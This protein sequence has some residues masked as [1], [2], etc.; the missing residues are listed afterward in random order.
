MTTVDYLG[1]D[2]G[3][4]RGLLLSLSRDLERL[5]SGLQPGPEDL[6]AAPLLRRWGVVQRP[7]FALQGRTYGHPAIDDGRI[8]VASEVFAIDRRKG[9]AR[10][11]S[12]YYSL[13]SSGLYGLDS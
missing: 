13:G 9:W 11:L 10:T 12:R 4:I 6:V 2:P 5:E 7:C 8:A 1:S 3:H